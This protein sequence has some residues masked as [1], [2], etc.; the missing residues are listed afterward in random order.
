[1]RV[2]ITRTWPLAAALLLGVALC[3]HAANSAEPVFGVRAGINSEPSGP[4]VGGELLA[5]MGSSWWFNPNVEYVAG[6]GLDLVGMSA[7]F[8]Y[9]FAVDRPALLWAGMGPTVILRDY[10]NARLNDDTDIGLNLL[11]GLGWRTNGP[12]PYAQG[13]VVLADHSFGSLGFGLRF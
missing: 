3:P 5:S 9:D 4:L 11:M 12:M 2:N 8:H 7:D 10:D 1:M 6:D 13:K